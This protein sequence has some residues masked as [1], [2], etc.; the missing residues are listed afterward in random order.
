MLAEW[1]SPS[2][3]F[4]LKPEYHSLLSSIRTCKFDALQVRFGTMFLHTDELC[5]R[6]QRLVLCKKE[7]MY[8]IRSHDVPVIVS[9][10][11]TTK[12]FHE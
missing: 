10:V 9:K 8:G 2:I 3:D 4:V 11:N 7:V 6:V 12:R 1:Y 5:I